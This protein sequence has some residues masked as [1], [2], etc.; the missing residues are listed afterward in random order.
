MSE[1]QDLYRGHVIFPSASRGPDP[2][3]PFLAGYFVWRAEGNN[4]YTG[5]LQGGCGAATFSTQEEAFAA[6]NASAK[7]AVD[8][9]LD[10]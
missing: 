7:L 5:V 10:S 9:L 8:K 1:F 4:N 2:R 3:G 6:A